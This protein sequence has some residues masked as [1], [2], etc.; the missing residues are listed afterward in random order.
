MVIYGIDYRTKCPSAN[1]FV[2][3]NRV[4][5]SWP[6][7]ETGF[8]ART[9]QNGC[10]VRQGLSSIAAKVAGVCDIVSHNTQS[11]RYAMHHCIMK[12]PICEYVPYTGGRY[13]RYLST[14]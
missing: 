7:Y 4:P 1:C 11:N 8:A 2:S 12:W 13:E 9:G 14:S 3:I 10:Y 6:V 5:Y